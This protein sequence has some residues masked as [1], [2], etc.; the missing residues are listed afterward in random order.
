MDECCIFDRLTCLLREVFGQGS[1]VATPELTADQVQDWD[2][3]GNVRLFMEIESEFSICFNVAEIR[4][5]KNV[6]DLARLI[7]LKSDAGKDTGAL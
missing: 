1:L 5:L 2:S 6:G 4:A 7:A 3:L